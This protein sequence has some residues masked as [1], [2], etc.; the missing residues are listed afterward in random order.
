MS[1]SWLLFQEY[2]H[3]HGVAHRD[4]KPENLLLD[5]HLNLKISDFG[6][7]TIFRMQGKV[8]S[9][10]S[11]AAFAFSMTLYICYVMNTVV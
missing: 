2:L 7:A 10:R 11:S 8:I 9:S 3:S 6:M 1:L 5:E 4:L